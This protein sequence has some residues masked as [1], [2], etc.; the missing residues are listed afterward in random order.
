[1]F[2]RYSSCQNKKVENKRDFSEDMLNLLPRMAEDV[3]RG[4]NGI[5]GILGGLTDSSGP[6]YFAGMAA[7]RVKR[8][9]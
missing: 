4:V 9:Y 3:P 7:L 2:A 6:V 5:I 1:M 8:H